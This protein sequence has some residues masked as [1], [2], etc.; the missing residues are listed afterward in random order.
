MMQSGRGFGDGVHG[1]AGRGVEEEGG[2]GLNLRLIKIFN[3]IILAL[4]II[5][6]VPCAQCEVPL[7]ILW[8]RSTL[9]SLTNPFTLTVNI[10]SSFPLCTVTKVNV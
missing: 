8:T 3:K 7:T 6:Y 2:S 9:L 4:L 5:L 1:V 10:M